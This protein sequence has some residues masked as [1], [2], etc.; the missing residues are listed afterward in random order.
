M[1][2][3][4]TDHAAL[5]ERVAAASGQVGVS[6][7][8]DGVFLKINGGTEIITAEQ[9]EVVWDVLMIR[10]R[11]GGAGELSKSEEG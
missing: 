7:S 3:C 6:M 4:A 9:A 8:K 10:M 5:I 1:T 2:Y 11:G